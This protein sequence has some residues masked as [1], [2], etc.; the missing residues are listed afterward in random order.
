YVVNPERGETPA[1][2]AHEIG[3]PATAGIGREVRGGPRVARGEGSAHVLAD[4]EMLLGD[5][6]AQPRGELAR[7]NIQR[8][9]R[10]LEHARGQPAPA[11]MRGADAPAVAR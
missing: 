1:R 7:G 3:L 5:R 11:G 4:F 2:Q 9:D 6:R 10:V 8:R